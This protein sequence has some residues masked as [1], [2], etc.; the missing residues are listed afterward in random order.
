LFLWDSYPSWRR[1][2]YPEYK[3]RSGRDPVERENIYTQIALF[4][5]LLSNIGI[6]QLAYPELEADDLAG[7]VVSR[8]RKK[9]ASV[10]M[11]SS[12]K[13]W[14][15]LLGDN[16]VQIRGWKGK[17]LDRWTAERLFTE[18]GVPATRW[19]EYLALVGDSAD[20]I[21]GVR[22]GVGPVAAKKIMAG[23][24]VTLTNAEEELLERNLKLTRVT[25]EADNRVLESIVFGTHTKEG[26]THM[27]DLLQEYELFAM[28]GERM[29][30]WEVGGWRSK[31]DQPG[32]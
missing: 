11:V 30:I 20:N 3:A 25:T 2:I 24:G 27:E 19:A 7:I 28:W 14:M 15:Q 13:D 17:R 22:H 9:K 6:A 23:T 16:V 1:K 5:K 10:I 26:W 29:R 32:T 12:D 8:L 4:R 18:H 31:S 21:P